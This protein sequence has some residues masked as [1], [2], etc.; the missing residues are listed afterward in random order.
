MITSMISLFWAVGTAVLPPWTLEP[1]AFE[2]SMTALV[3]VLLDGMQQEQGFLAAFAGSSVRGLASAGEPTPFGPFIGQRFFPIMIYANGNGEQISFQFHVESL[4]ATAA[5]T[6]TFTADESVGGL[7]APLVL[8]CTTIPLPSP[9]SL[10]WPSLP[11]HALPQQQLV[12]SILPP[13]VPSPQLLAVVS[14]LQPLPP[15]GPALLSPLPP[16][17][18]P[19]PV[20]D[21]PSPLLPGQSL[22]NA[23]GVSPLVAVVAI[24]VV[25]AMLTGVQVACRTGSNGGHLALMEVQMKGLQSFTGSDVV[26]SSTLTGERPSHPQ[27]VNCELTGGL[28]TARAPLTKLTVL[29]PRG[30]CPDAT[31]TL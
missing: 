20:G 13:S 3:S 24:V 26:I 9:P 21:P 22:S 6:L 2:R 31:E 7:T 19:V 5:E 4:V 30:L 14:P 25:L 10:P 1:A 8:H 28:S 15:Q 11:S 29:G 27:H 18:S 23:D 17:A 16:R 12:L